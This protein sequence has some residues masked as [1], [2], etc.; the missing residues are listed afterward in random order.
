[1]SKFDPKTLGGGVNGISVRQ[2]TNS[3]KSSENVMMRRVVTKSWNNQ[4]SFGVINNKNRAIGPF[5]A[6]NNMGDFLSRQNYVCGGSNTSKRGS[7]ISRCD[8]TGI[9]SSTANNRWVSDSSD[10]TKFK[11]QKIA[12][13]LYNDNSL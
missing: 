5:R 7:M 2:T 3:M 11:K 13:S 10:Y 12:N 6:V 1:M 4:N 9:S 8:G